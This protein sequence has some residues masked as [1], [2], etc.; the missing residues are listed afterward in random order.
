VV[1]HFAAINHG[2]LSDPKVKVIINDGRNYLL[3]T[4]AT[5]DAILSDSIHPLFA[6]NSALYTREY[7]EM[8]RDH[9][10]PGGVVS[11]WLPM[12]SLDRGSYLRILRA[13]YEVFPRTA[14]WYDITTVNEFTVVT[15]LVDPGPIDLRWERMHAPGVA[16]SLAIA[17]VYS[18]EDLM[19]N[20]LLGPEDVAMLTA[21][22]PAFEDDL[23]YVEYTSGRLLARRLTWYSNLK[24]LA[25]ARTTRSPFAD[26]E[27]SWPQ[28][29]ARRD[30]SLRGALHMLASHQ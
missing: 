22:V 8:C 1:F 4:D 2:I 15:G 26:H 27:T 5:Y 16:E 9:L 14:V 20:L 19:A 12:Y 6:G 10:N 23:P 3:A 13:F 25:A 7:F 24:L 21:M 30:E 17:G 11:M 29:A 28:A 18:E